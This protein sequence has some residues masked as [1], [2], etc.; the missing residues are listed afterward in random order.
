MK[1]TGNTILITGGTSGI[2]LALSE[3][4]LEAGNT[5]I[6]CGRRVNKLKEIKKKYPKINTFV[7][8]VSKEDERRK[9]FN[10][11]VSNFPNVNILINNAGIQRPIDLK[12]GE[13]ELLKGEDEIEV[14]LK[15]CIHLASLF[16]PDFLTKESAIVNISSGLGFVPITRFPVYCATKAAIHTYTISLRHQLKDASI[17]VFEIIPPTVDTELDKGK[18]PPTRR[19]IPASEVSKAFLEALGK[20]GFEIAV[21]S[22]AGLKSGNFQENF[23]RMNAY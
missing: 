5:I 6:I 15:A 8:D 23:N 2:G 1:T 4:L 9:M 13:S 12:K 19:G 20:D 18:R 16:I 10:W 7:C 3:S 21:G 22:A 14:N 17:K 11:T